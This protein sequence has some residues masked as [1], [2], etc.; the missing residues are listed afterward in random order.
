MEANGALD[1]QQPGGR[2]R[3][4]LRRWRPASLILLLAPCYL[5]AILTKG[6]GLF[7]D[8]GIYLVTAKA[9]AESK[10]YTVGSLPGHVLQT[11]YPI[12]FPAVLSLVWRILPTFPDNV[13]AL[14]L[15]P[16][17]CMMAFL[18]ITYRFGR[19]AAGISS[20]AMLWILFFTA[21]TPWCIFLA[22]NVMSEPLFALFTVSTLF[23]LYHAKGRGWRWRELL[24]AAF[25][26]GAAYQTRSAGASLMASCVWYLILSRK[27]KQ[28]AIF[29]AICAAIVVA[30]GHWQ[31]Q[32]TPTSTE[33]EAYY[34]AQSYKTSSVIT[35]TAPRLERFE[36]GLFNVVYLLIY[37]LK[38]FVVPFRLPLHWLV[39]VLMGF[40]F[41]VFAARGAYRF[42][43]L[44]LTG[45][46]LATYIAMI[47]LWVGEPSR[48]LLPVLPFLLILAYKGLPK[49]FPRMI[50]PVAALGPL[51][52]AGSYAVTSQANQWSCFGEVPWMKKPSGYHPAI[53]GGK[54]Y[55]MA[56]WVKQNTDRDSVVLS[57]SDPA[58][59]LA[60]ERKSIRPYVVDEMGLYY[61]P[62]RDLQ[63]KL[64]EFEEV[65]SRSGATFLTETGR[66]EAE[67]PD[68]PKILGELEGRGRIQLVKNFGANYRVYRI[69]A[70]R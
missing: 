62:S 40:P 39:M 15:V 44:R 29:A 22:T 66:E 3:I 67:D 36:I 38:V 35:M 5:A 58:L 19:K 26:A 23:A 60:S 8:D 24:S 13:L 25:L 11:K 6:A 12:I 34:T 21:A 2:R 49:R 41:W 53:D 64:R 7:H 4:D 47:T 48:F 52:L 68:Y 28:A 16:A 43:E 37:P 30:W 65:I 70:G 10:G 63:S 50:A 1:N 57:G 56:N 33:A 46:F 18:F 9:L 42:P 59:F 31:T 20:G 55:Q 69:E 61:S 51:V 27:F 54:F 14:K 45:L 17:L 32:S